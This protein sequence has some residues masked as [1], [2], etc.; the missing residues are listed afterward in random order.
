MKSADESIIDEFFA[1]ATPVI[2]E[3]V[4]G[5]LRQGRPAD[6]ITLVLERAFDGSVSGKCGPRESIV[7]LFESDAR[8]PDPSRSSV[9][10]AIIGAGADEIPAVAMIQC[11]GYIVVGAR[12]LSGGLVSVS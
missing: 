6:Q 10:E 8:I 5:A 7:R 4:T 11:E 3:L 12:R 1:A 9:V 2:E